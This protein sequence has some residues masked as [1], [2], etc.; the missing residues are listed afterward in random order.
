MEG[1]KKKKKK[2][3]RVRDCLCLLKP[4]DDS[5]RLESKR[6]YSGSDPILATEM[7]VPLNVGNLPFGEVMEHARW[8]IWV[9]E[10]NDEQ[11]LSAMSMLRGE[12]PQVVSR[13]ITASIPI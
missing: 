4:W 5:T 7:W 6:T 10:V 11:T 2:R 1:K 13:S 12:A 3:A 8:L 9:L